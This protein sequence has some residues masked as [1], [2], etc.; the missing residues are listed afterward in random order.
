MGKARWVRKGI[1]YILLLSLALVAAAIA[2][3]WAPDKPV[4]ELKQRWAPPPSQFIAVKGLQVHLRDE[5]PRDDPLPIVLIHGTSASLHTWEGWVAALKGR[6]RVITMDLPGFGL[7]GPNAQDDYSN[8]TYIQ[9]MLDLVDTLGVQR[10]VLGGNSLGG[11][12]AW[13]VAAAAPQRVDK[14]ILVDAGGYAYQPKSVP[15][16]FRIARTP[17]LNKLMEVTLPRSLIEKSVRN[18]YGDPGRVTP[19]LVDRYVAMTLRQGNRH[20]LGKRFNQLDAGAN[21]ATIKTLK[22]PTLIIWGMQD[23]LIPLEYGQRFHQDIAASK[24]VQFK[25]LG[26]VPHEEDPTGTVAAVNA[27]LNE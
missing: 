19:E 18:V 3:S 10:F 15:I 11:E 26:H 9:F 27:F 21:A 4:A 20:A 5:G 17:G 2:L 25:R 24:F 1:L 13:Q 7:T 23:R 16:G 22:L 12:I 6:H 14:L 8:A